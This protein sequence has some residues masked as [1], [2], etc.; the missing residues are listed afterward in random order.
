MPQLDRA[1]I[2]TQIF[3]LFIV[4]SGSYIILT[5]FFFPLFV[6]S[7]KSR[8]LIVE[9]NSIELKKIQENFAQN[10][11][12]LAQVLHEGLVTVKSFYS[13]EFLLKNSTKSDSTLLLIDS[14][15]VLIMLNIILYCDKNT[16]SSISLSSRTYNPIYIE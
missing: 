10:Q 1:I 13:S 15:L 6:K 14:K 5:H 16:L 4:F 8:K 12:I 7:L 9:M 2:F 3:W 11:S